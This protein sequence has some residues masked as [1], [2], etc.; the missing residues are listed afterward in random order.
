MLRQ[1]STYGYKIHF[2][3]NA[4]SAAALIRQFIKLT[5]ESHQSLTT[6][7][8]EFGSLVRPGD[9]EIIILLTDIYDCEPDWDKETISRGQEL[10]EKPW[11]NLIAATT[12]RWM[13]DNL[14]K[15]SVEGGFVRRVLF[16]YREDYNLV[17]EPKMTDEQKKLRQDLTHDLAHIASLEGQMQYANKEVFEYYKDWYE[18]PERIKE[19]RDSRLA[20]YFSC[21]ADHIR[22]VAMLISLAEGDT[23]KIDLHHFKTAL[24]LV[25]ELE[26]GMLKALSSVG[27]N[28][29]NT[30]FDRIIEQVMTNG[31]ITY[32]K[33]FNM[34]VFALEKRQ[35]D[36][37]LETL[38]ELDKIVV[39]NGVVYSPVGWR[40]EQKAQELEKKGTENDQSER[41]EEH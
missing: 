18:N 21:K 3:S 26:P 13:T 6:F 36:E 37:S 30:D 10:I 20:G 8:S 7:S 14:E 33:L 15:L 35:F 38:V 28:P 41:E 19:A 25:E 27:K 11:L 29:F 39:K 24:N 5:N 31:R 17:A 32:K 34:N 23:L 1:V 4:A 2:T 16:V 9:N 12:P 40:L 22:K